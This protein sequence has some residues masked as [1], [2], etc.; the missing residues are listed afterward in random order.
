MGQSAP[1]LVHSTFSFTQYTKSGRSLS[2]LKNTL[3]DRHEA[4]GFEAFIH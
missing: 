1:I 2:L 4:L 3:L